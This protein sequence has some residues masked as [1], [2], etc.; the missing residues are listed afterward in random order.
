MFT[1]LTLAA[2]VGIVELQAGLAVTGDD[3]A[4]SVEVA[5]TSLVL[6]RVSDSKSLARSYKPTQMTPV[7]P[8]PA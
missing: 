8:P 6:E 4:A 2:E 5:S 3:V 1:R 7:Q